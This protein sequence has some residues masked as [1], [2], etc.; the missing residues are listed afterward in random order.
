[1]IPYIRIIPS[2]YSSPPTIEK[3]LVKTD[4]RNL[5][6]DM[7]EE[8]NAS[9]L[10]QQLESRTVYCSNFLKVQHRNGYAGCGG[11]V[12]FVSK[13]SSELHFRGLF[14]SNDIPFQKR[15]PGSGLAILNVLL[16]IPHFLRF[17]DVVD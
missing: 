1:M 14:H 13:D 4:V 12:C 5:L 11:G 15:D 6:A 2:D 16:G 8:V 17:F 3:K 10:E 9:R 7:R